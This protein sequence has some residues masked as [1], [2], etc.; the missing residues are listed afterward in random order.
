MSI[1]IDHDI[2][3][4]E[5]LVRNTSSSENAMKFALEFYCLP[6]LSNFTIQ[7]PLHKQ[8]HIA[9]P[10]SPSSFSKVNYS[11]D[12]PQFYY[13]VSQ[14]CNQLVTEKTRKQSIPKYVHSTFL[15]STS[16]YEIHPTI[17]EKIV[18]DE[19]QIYDLSSSIAVSSKL[20][21]IEMPIGNL[22]VCF[23][24]SICTTMSYLIALI[25]LL[26]KLC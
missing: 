13:R 19:Y 16:K 2:V 4:S 25:I 24:I 17:A 5:V 9:A 10:L 6:I 3:P 1:W 23:W 20:M 12:I 21:N 18:L 14:S 7:F 26:F 15:H 11:I 8:Y 22:E